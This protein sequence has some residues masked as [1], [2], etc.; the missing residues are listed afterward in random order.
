MY[1][2]PFFFA[3]DGVNTFRPYQTEHKQMIIE[4][5]NKGGEII[6]TI[7]GIRKENIV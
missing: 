7:S 5:M 2:I 3:Y 6:K 1:L 4:I